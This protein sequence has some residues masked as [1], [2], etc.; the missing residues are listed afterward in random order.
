MLKLLLPVLL[1]LVFQF[2]NQT[3]CAGSTAKI[4]RTQNSI[5]I[6]STASRFVNLETKRVG[7]IQPEI[8][9]S[10]RTSS[11][12]DPHLDPNAVTQGEHLDPM[13]DGVFARAHLQ[14]T[15]PLI[16]EEGRN[17][18]FQSPIVEDPNAV[19]QGEHLDPTRDGVFARIRNAALRYG[20]AALAGT[21]IGGLGAVA[22]DQLL[23]HFKDE[24][25]NNN[26]KSTTQSVTQVKYDQKMNNVNSI[27]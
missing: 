16:A 25:N 15:E 1:V 2:L 21:A 14:D 20:S 22:S 5:R 4:P 11:N 23:S 19:T 9:P 8:E 24:N 26:I 17:V 7:A 18:R 27:P 13:R 12:L 10:V 6:P 3:E